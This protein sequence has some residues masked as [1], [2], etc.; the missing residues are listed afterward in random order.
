MSTKEKLNIQG[1][2]SIHTEN[3]LPIIKKWLYSE[4][5]IFIRE[6]VSNAYDACKKRKYIASTTGE[7]VP[8]A[9]INIDFNEKEKTITISDNGI[10]LNAE[11]VQKY[12]NQIAFS[13]AEDF[14]KKYKGKDEKNQVIGH[15]GL[16]FYSSFIVSDLVEIKSLSHNKNEKAVHW[17]CEGSTKF[18]L[19][20]SDKKNVGTDIILHVNKESENYLNEAKLSEL[21]KKYANFLPVKIKLK[22]KQINDDAPLWIKDPKDIKD[23]EYKEFYQKLLPMQGEPLFWIHLN[24][25]YPF[26]LQ[27]I[28]Y[29]PKLL[30]ELDA[31]KGKINL[32][33]QQVFVTEN[34]KDIVPEFL[35]LLQGAIDCPDI[36]LNVSR[37]YLQND[38]IV[39]KISSHI[40]KKIGDKLNELYKKDKASYEKYWND[41]NPFIKY[42]VMNDDTFFKKIKDIILFKSSNGYATTLSEYKER[43]EKDLKEKVLYCQNQESLS[44]YVE[45]C[46]AQ[47]LE[48]LYLEA[49]IDS[50]FIQYLESKNPD[51]KFVSVDSELSELLQDKD[52]NK[53]VIDPKTNK[54]KQDEIKDIVTNALNNEKLVIKVEA[55]KAK[56]IPAMIIQDEHMKRFEQM[57]SMMKGPKQ[58][59]DN[60][61]LI[62]N[63]E[64]E[65]VSRLQQLKALN[66][67][68]KIKEIAE[69]LYDLA[70]LGQKPL[71]GKELQ[72]FLS[73]SFA[74]LTKI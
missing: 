64:N 6:L 63:S 27:G 47:N 19:K 26:N 18:E 60:H 36:P 40:V 25:D 32:F 70:K 34:A 46:K 52:K 30:H 59:F 42:G 53:N 45:I 65:I 44:T 14:I 48:V 2:I 51:Q 71:S 17:S 31:N 39:K 3:I 54:N 21:I 4:N 55:L 67:G 58:S 35:T 10:G 74:L 73:R 72:N 37:S 50:H 1:D 57:S 68:D 24:V 12:I 13:G 49:V 29:F 62:L 8:E 16:G 15:F 66:Q 61:T 5:E 23:E 41:I 56:E 22:D 38:P 11:E 28:L 9:E 7:T 20:E 69:Q 43:N 33:C